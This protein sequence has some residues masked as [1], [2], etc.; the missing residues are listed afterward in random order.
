MKKL[1]PLLILVVVAASGFFLGRWI[2][3][4][5]AGSDPAATSDEPEVLYWV[6]PM[7][8]R[9]RRDEPGKSPMG[10]DLVPVYADSGGQTDPAVV[11]IDPAVINNLGV[12]TA[13]VESGSLPRIIDTVGYV[14][15]D[16]STLNHIHSRADG[17]IEKLNIDST[18]ESVER[19]QVLFELYSPA[20]VNAQEEFVA[21]LASKSSALREA[22][23][24]RLRS[25]GFGES[26]I[27]ALQKTRQVQQRVRFYAPNDGI[28][29]QLLVREGM[30]VTPA[31]EIMSLG[32]LDKIWLMVEVFERQV[33][34]VEPGQRAEVQLDY[35]PGRIWHGIVDY[36]YP[37]LSPGTRTARVRI[38]FDNP[39]RSLR[40]N[41]FAGI[42][43]FGTAV[44]DAIHI[45]QQALIRGGS[46][47]RVVLAEG[48][49]RF[50]SRPVVAGIESGDRI[51]ILS[52]LSVG[53]TVVSSG[54]FLIDSESNIDAEIARMEQATG[55]DD[56]SNHKQAE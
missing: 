8:A 26:Q 32:Q 5:D 40:P 24:N 35:L 49:G 27:K 14:A 54:Q 23:A 25:L 29:V 43:I 31:I 17:W 38:R 46:V 42:R 53:E 33:A 22:S 41:M 56:H 3:P 37:E 52:G 13:V 48:D 36:V 30:Y 44:P 2:F 21:G 4:G 15:Y 39:D 28:V 51:Q 6:A 47:D 10:M 16:E 19:G 45:P 1:S 7:D 9:Y 12:R 50:R 34:W 20:L 55:A 11:R 18:G